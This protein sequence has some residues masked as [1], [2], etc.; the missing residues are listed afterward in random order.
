MSKSKKVFLEYIEEF[1][2]FAIA[3]SELA[4]LKESGTTAEIRLPQS[5]SGKTDPMAP[6]LGVLLGQDTAKNGEKYYSIGLNYVQALKNTGAN[7]RFIDFDNAYAEAKPCDGA[8]LIGGAFDN[9]E[10]FF[11]DG[12]DMGAKEGKR[13]FA[14]KSIINEAYA[15][16]KPMLGICAG[17]QMI[18]ALLGAMKMYRS[19]KDEVPE[20]A[21]HKPKKETDVKMHAIKLLKDTP[22]FAIMDIKENENRVMINSRHT[23][24]MVHGALQDYVKEKP[25]VK[26]DLYAIS[27]ADG[28]PEIWGNEKAGILCIQGHPE[29]LAARGDE[30]MQKLYNHIAQLAEK[31]HKTKR[32]AKI[33]LKNKENTR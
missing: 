24:A 6:T 7:L 10:S 18:G 8:V 20:H 19:I 17:A 26:M 25:L 5:V 4:T 2:A 31:Y 15:A 29:D 11:I 9:P 30:K 13:F 1:K 14:Y 22:I 23:Q 27:E 32:N 3:Q 16:K 21:V 33:P 12:K 28:V